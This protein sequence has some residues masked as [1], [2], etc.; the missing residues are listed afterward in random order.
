MSDVSQGH[1]STMKSL[2]GGETFSLVVDAFC[3]CTVRTMC[4]LRVFQ[5][6]LCSLLYLA[7]TT[8]CAVNVSDL[9]SSV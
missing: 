8:V 7:A 1:S 5:P 3:R 6:V 9:D 2:L 4:W